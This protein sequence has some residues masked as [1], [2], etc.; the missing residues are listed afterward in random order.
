MDGQPIKEMDWST[1]E[2]IDFKQLKENPNK[3]K[4]ESTPL[5]QSYRSWKIEITQIFAWRLMMRRQYYL[6]K[7]L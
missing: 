1:V 3:Y 6:C 5:E 2:P 7:I 4:S